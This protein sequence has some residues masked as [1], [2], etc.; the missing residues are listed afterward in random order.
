MQPKE[1]LHNSVLV[2]QARW[3][4]PADMLRVVNDLLRHKG[5]VLRTGTAVDTT[6]ISG[7]VR[8]RTPTGSAIRR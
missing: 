7:R 8:P 4:H 1:G 2:R 3:R 6:L 5:L